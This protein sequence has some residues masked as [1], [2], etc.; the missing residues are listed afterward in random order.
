MPMP[1]QPSS[2]PTRPSDCYT[3]RQE[4]ADHGTERRE[5]I[6]AT[7]RW[8]LVHSFDSALEGWLVLLPRRHVV[9]IHDLTGEEAAEL[10]PLLRRVSVALRDELS[11]DKTYV[12]QLAEAEGFSHVHFHVVP[13]S[14]ELPTDRRG[15]GV[16]WYLRQ[17]EEAW[18][19]VDR[20]EELA[21]AIGRRLEA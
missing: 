8:R 11:C 3:C 6:L 16:F 18:V 1:D 9:A 17:P 19:S 21:T 2:S 20:Q 7:D 10:G 13:R 4:V 5:R 15:P 14:A 12:I